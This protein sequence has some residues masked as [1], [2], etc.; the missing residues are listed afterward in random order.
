MDRDGFEIIDVSERDI[1]RIFEPAEQK[2]HQS[3]YLAA[4]FTFMYGFP[5]LEN[6]S[7][8]QVDDFP[9]AGEELCSMLMNR[10]ASFDK[11][12]SEAVPGGLMLNNGPSTSSDLDGM[13]L[14]VPPLLLEGNEGSISPPAARQQLFGRFKRERGEMEP[15][16][17]IESRED[18]TVKLRALVTDAG[19]TAGTIRT[20]A[21]MIK[22][23]IFRD[24]HR[25]AGPKTTLQLAE[26]L[27]E[28]GALLYVPSYLEG[29]YADEQMA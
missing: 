13:E 29:E 12:H 4:L 18:A 2:G 24:E 21:E 22:E 9:K 7:V 28:D 11:E 16:E 1:N 17:W 10:A 15:R 19:K 27:R 6:D 14:A 8:E 26:M 25:H 5:V 23:P 20:L 3:A